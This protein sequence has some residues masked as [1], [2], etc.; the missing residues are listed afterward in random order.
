VPPARTRR[1][2]DLAAVAALASFAVVAHAPSLAGGWIVDDGHYV[3]ENPLLNDAAGL[4]TIWLQPSASS[5]YYPLTLTSFWI[6][7]QLFDLDPRAF[8]ATNLLLHAA[9]AVM[10]WSVLRRLAAT[11][12][13]LIAALFAVHPIHV[14]TVAWISERKNLL[15]GLLALLTIGLYL[16]FERRRDGD[17]GWR[18]YVGS[19]LAFVLAMLS[20]SAV[21][22]VPVV[23][24]LLA[25]WRRGRLG[26]RGLVP[27]VPFVA[28]GAGLAALTVHLESRLVEVGDALA[29]PA[30]HER[31]LL[32]ARAALFYLGKIVWPSGLSFDYGGWPTGAHEPVNLA[33]ALV[34]L[35]ALVLLW[36]RREWW[37]RGPLV[38]LLVFFVSAAPA[39]GL[40]SFYFHRY[41]FVADH[42]VYLPSLPI[43]ALCVAAGERLLANGRRLW[44]GG[45]IAS[46]VLA[47]LAATTWSHAHDYRDHET[48]ARA[49]LRV[50]PSSWL[51]HNHLGNE[52]LRRGDLAAALEHLERAE[53]AAS[54]RIETQVNLALVRMNAGDLA[55]AEAAARRV[56]ALRDGAEIG[57][58]LLGDSLLR[59]GRFDAAVASY[60]AALERDPAALR[61]RAGLGLA[62]SRAGRHSAA[63][64]T[65]VTVLRD[66]PGNVAA[67]TGLAFS[68]S[69]LGR[70]D[71]AIAELER[72]LSLAPDD[73]RLVRNLELLRA[74]GPP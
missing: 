9:V 11:G 56:I 5:Q 46:V 12:S 66:D 32:A 55:G 64:A 28:V 38:A 17:G 29:T 35:A 15:A 36:V 52:A 61:S 68:L 45:A 23:L 74:G 43:L 67:R 40:V 20:K 47:A 4:A 57:Y 7:R 41:G 42:F 58:R 1:A 60:A 2:A 62:Q 51:A 71:E 33:S 34:L 54:G 27:L 31:P 50:N 69:A 65:L 16:D 6:E 19:L 72:A 30:L 10:A 3:T 22:G 39:L 26:P 53:Q 63:V 49:I 13:W 21:V 48:L 14:D 24:A 73:P 37:G 44:L 59:A 8:H 25:W 70:R 18:L